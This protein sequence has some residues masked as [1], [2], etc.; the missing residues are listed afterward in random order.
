MGSPEDGTNVQVGACTCCRAQ[1]DQVLNV[2]SCHDPSPGRRVFKE[3]K[4]KAAVGSV[5]REKLGEQAGAPDRRPARQINVR[6][7]GHF[8]SIYV[9]GCYHISTTTRALVRREYGRHI[10]LSQNQF[11][12][13][14]GPVCRL[15]HAYRRLPMITK[16]PL[17]IMVKGFKTAVKRPWVCGEP[18]GKR[19]RSG[20]IAAFGIAASF[21][22][23]WNDGDENIA[24]PAWIQRFEIGTVETLR[25]EL[26]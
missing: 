25:T 23:R 1:G 3:P 24:I 16:F 18:G 20:L 12:K 2:R 4:T 17:T 8:H 9:L 15:T 10:S 21:V 7:F 26:S 5:A 14:L 22:G 6:L 13:N 19:V 11:G